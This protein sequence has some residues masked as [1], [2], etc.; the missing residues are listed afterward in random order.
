M[1]KRSSIKTETSRLA[2]FTCNQ[3]LMRAA[4]FSSESRSSPNQR[5]LLQKCDLLLKDLCL[6]CCSTATRIWLLFHFCC[7]WHN[8]GQEREYFKR[9]WQETYKWQQR[10]GT[11]CVVV[12]WSSTKTEFLKEIIKEV[13]LVFSWKLC[14]V[15]IIVSTVSVFQNTHM[16]CQW[17][18]MGSNQVKGHSYIWTSG[19]SRSPCAS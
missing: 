11:G 7:N 17:P 15:L 19:L 8:N 1:M 16:L 18:C 4:I 5:R 3:F 6:R 13:S 14:M 12:H 10:C 9:R 2:V